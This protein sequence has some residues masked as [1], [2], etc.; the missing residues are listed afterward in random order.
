MNT[1][2]KG[3]LLMASLVAAEDRFNRISGGGMSTP[4]FQLAMERPRSYGGTMLHLIADGVTLCGVRVPVDADGVGGSVA[5]WTDESD[6][7]PKCK[8]CLRS[9]KA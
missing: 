4:V 1:E 8:R 6:G 7:I 9:R 5:M 2:W 3:W